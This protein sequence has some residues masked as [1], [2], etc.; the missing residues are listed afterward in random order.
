VNT[1]DDIGELYF[2]R[3]YAPF[4][5]DEPVS[6]LILKLKYSCDGLVA[7]TFAP[8]M[9]ECLSDC[10]YDCVVPVPLSKRRYRERGYNQALLLCEE[11]AIQIEKKFGKKI[12]V[13]DKVLIRTK[14]TTPQVDMDT[15]T[16]IQNQ[17]DA[18]EIK[19]GERIKEK[20]VLLIDDVLT[21]G[22]TANECAKSLVGAGAIVSVLTV[23][24]VVH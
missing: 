6:N 2:D 23:A 18:F 17:S 8:F 10:M 16:R 7:K 13:V 19:N 11:V 21:S 3:I 12:D 9:A 15:K 22:A 24:R 4:V 5:Y 14:Q 1:L 20:R